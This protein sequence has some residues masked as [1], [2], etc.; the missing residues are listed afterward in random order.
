MLIPGTTSVTFRKMTPSE[1]IEITKRCGLKAIEWGGDI[2]VPHGD[3]RK[4]EEV[5]KMTED[6]GLQVSSY[7]SYYEA[8]CDD[9][10]LPFEKVLVSASALKAPVI[11]IWAGNLASGI[12]DAVYRKK[13][14]DDSRRVIKMAADAGISVAFEYH[15]NTLTDTVG[16]AD[17][18][19]KDL[20]AV[21][22]KL[23]WQIPMDID[24]ED[25]LPGL[26]AAMPYLTNIHMFYYQNGEQTLLCDGLNLWKKILGKVKK[27]GKD[28]FCLLEFVK[29]ETQNSFEA[30]AETLRQ[31]CD[32]VNKK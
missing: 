7:G 6:A 1:I 13:V 32:E 15:E 20:Q 4:A 3:V 25:C 29:D 28:H 19:M 8:G 18:L 24:P 16:S 14:T 23:Y 21:S 5:Y 31:L 2:H 11:R 27:D 17:R 22:G 10:E 26:T 30:D 9:P 12:C